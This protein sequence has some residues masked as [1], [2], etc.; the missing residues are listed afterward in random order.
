MLFES[1]FIQIERQYLIPKMVER[2]DFLMNPMHQFI[3]PNEKNEF[4]VPN[5]YNKKG[6]YYVN[7]CLSKLQVKL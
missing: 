6:D 2:E 3:Y 4:V 7:Q 1:M 5:H